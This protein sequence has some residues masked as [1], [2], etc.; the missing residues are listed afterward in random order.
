[1]TVKVRGHDQG[2]KRNALVAVGKGVVAQKRPGQAGGDDRDA[3]FP[4]VVVEMPRS[5]NSGLQSILI[6]K[7]R[8]SAVCLDKL[9]VDVPQHIAA[10]EYEAHLAS[11]R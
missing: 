4:R 5:R 10:E 3:G 11:S 2:G 1:M 7:P 8:K 6:T 9:C